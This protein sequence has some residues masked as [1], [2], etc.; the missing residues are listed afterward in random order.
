MLK[1]FLDKQRPLFEKQGKL[2]HYQPIFAALD[3]FLYTSGQVTSCAPHVRDGLNIKKTMGLVVIALIPCTL[4]GLYNT[5]LQANLALAHAGL[6]EPAGWRFDLLRASGLGFSPH[7]V[8]ANVLHGFFYFFPVLLVSNLVGGAWEVV[9]SCQRNQE[10]HEGFLVTGLLFPLILPP[11][12][13]LWLVA[14]GISFGIVIGKL[15]FGGIG[16]N[17][18]NPAL[19]G[20]AFLF[21]S[22]PASLTGE[23]VWTSS[24]DAVSGATPLGRA[25]AEGVAG[26]NVSWAQAFLGLMPGSMGETSTLACL[27]GAAI[28]LSAGIASWRIMLSICIG[29]VSLA[30][31]FNSSTNVTNPM[32][33]VTPAWHFVLGGFAFGAVFMATDPVTSA[34]TAKGQWLY[35]LLIGVMAVLIRVL[36]PGFP[37]GMMLA[38]LFGN[39]LAPLIDYLVVQ[40]TM[41][42]RLARHGSL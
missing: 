32:F 36:N 3:S 41:H 38:I 40:R 2:A 26:L 6:I 10:I 17:F 31:L 42:R 23:R 8:S 14:M 7:S 30:L 5:G 4:A 11:T 15:I 9:F 1:K 37:E 35:G 24:V 25:A 33:G 20:Y 18:L 16:R 21:F 13:P 39:C 19:T 12:I 34:V 29:M 22:Y 27:I 28:L